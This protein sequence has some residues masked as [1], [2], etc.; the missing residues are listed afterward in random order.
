MPVLQKNTYGP[1]RL[2]GSFPGLDLSA[3][4]SQE[5]QYSVT[6]FLVFQLDTFI[7]GRDSDV[8]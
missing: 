5:V 3:D 8:G 1:L 4:L 6:R 7:F 2:A